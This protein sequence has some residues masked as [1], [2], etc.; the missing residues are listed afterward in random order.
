MQK[1]L[2]L[3]A[4]VAI[5]LVF[6]TTACNPDENPP[7]DLP[8][9]VVFLTEDPTDMSGYFFE[10]F[11][12]EDTAA[13]V[14]LGIQAETGTSSLKSLTI[15]QDGTPVSTDRIVIRDLRTD[16]DVTANNPL[17]ITGDNTEGFEYEI[18]L[19][20]QDDFDVA[21]VY[22][23]DVT[24]E[25]GL[26]GSATI[27][28]TTIK[29]ATPLD[30]TLVGVLFNAAG[31]TGTGGLD[32]D[33][34]SSTGS[35]SGDAEIRDLGIDCAEPDADNWLAQFGTVNGADM[36]RVDPGSLEDFTFDGT[37]SKEVILQAYNTGAELSDGST[38]N[39]SGCDAVPLSVT[40]VAAPV[41]GDVFV[42][43]SGGVYYLIEVEEVNVTTSDNDDNY[44]L[45]I[46]Y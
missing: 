44:V 23:F 42:V 31:P 10:N 26:T 12:T 9:D 2:S 20:P 13:F 35:A 15:T 19:N 4:V 36:K 33:D 22:S 8:P 3:F 24:D 37:D 32:L 11:E 27:T 16:T 45:N 29:P 6:V 30:M 7:I 5:T 46:K 38:V 1:F 25:N 34:G 39:T 40:D 28:I 41:A 17:L 43:E 18:L 14:S 21:A